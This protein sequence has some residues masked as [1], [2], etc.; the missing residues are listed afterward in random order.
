[1]PIGRCE[2]HHLVPYNRGSHSG[3]PTDLQNLTLACS[4]HH[5]LAH[6]GGFTMSRNPVTGQ[7]DTRRPDGTIIPTRARA[8]LLDP[9]GQRQPDQDDPGDDSLPKAS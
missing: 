7:I 1:M 4:R 3:G 6:E 9:Y 8:G 5:H 2:V